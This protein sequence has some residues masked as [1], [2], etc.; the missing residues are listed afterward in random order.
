MY[1]ASRSIRIENG[2]NRSRGKQVSGG[3]TETTS[4]KIDVFR[5]YLTI[6]LEY[7]R[8]EFRIWYCIRHTI[9]APLFYRKF[10]GM[11]SMVGGINPNR[12]DNEIFDVIFTINWERSLG[13]FVNHQTNKLRVTAIH[14]ATC[15][16]VHAQTDTLCHTDS[17]S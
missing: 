8:N 14:N 4:T 3:S 15:L 10:C 11:H 16:K 5:V 9:D 7:V 2:R 13:N 17:S 1:N 6:Y 12:S